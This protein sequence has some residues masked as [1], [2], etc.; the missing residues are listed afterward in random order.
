MVNGLRNQ[1]QRH[2]DG[3]PL[4]SGSFADEGLLPAELGKKP[5]SF[6]AYKRLPIRA[7]CW[8]SPNTPDT[9]FVS[10]YITKRKDKL[11]AADTARVGAHFTRIEIDGDPP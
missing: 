4:A 9:W 7:Y 3:H 5:R 2:A 8:Q 6:K 10:H 1:L 11:D